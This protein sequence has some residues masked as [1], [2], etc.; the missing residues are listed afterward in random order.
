MIAIKYL[1]LVAVFIWIGSL[2]SLTRFMG[3]HVKESVD[4]QMRLSKLYYR[5]YRLIQ[6]P[7]MVVAVVL[8]TVLISQLDLSYK[9]GWFHI[10]LTCALGLIACDLFCGHCVRKLVLEPDCSRGAK[11]KALHGIT[12]LMLMG[13]LLGSVVVRDKEGEILHRHEIVAQME[14]QVSVIEEP[15]L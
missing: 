1:H 12:G 5:M 14:T 11:Y 7:T 6:F 2:M 8:G 4:T 15:S 13:L 3:Y 9:P 10:K